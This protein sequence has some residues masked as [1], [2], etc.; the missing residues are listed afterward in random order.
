VSRSSNAIGV[1][2]KSFTLINII[3]P[4]RDYNDQSIERRN[5]INP[6]VVQSIEFGFKILN[7]IHNSYRKNK[8]LFKHFTKIIGYID[9]IQGIYE[10]H[11]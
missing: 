10:L 7:L 1:G 11:I 5:L 6:L 4:N 2:G 3:H 9:Y 8:L